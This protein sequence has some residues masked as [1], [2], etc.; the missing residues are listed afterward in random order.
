MYVPRCSLDNKVNII[1]LYTSI[2]TDLEDSVYG[3]IDSSI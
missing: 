1:S 2:E 3:S